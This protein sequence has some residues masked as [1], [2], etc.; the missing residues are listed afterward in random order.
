MAITHQISDGPAHAVA[1]LYLTEGQTVRAEQGALVAMSPNVEL[2][3][4]TSEGVV[5]LL[6]EAGKKTRRT[7]FSNLYTPRNGGG[8]V[9]L[10]PMLPGSIE[11][12]NLEHRTFHVSSAA[13]L[14]CSPELELDI[15]IANA[16]TFFSAND[17]FLFGISGT[18]MLMLGA[19]GGCH[20]LTL[21]AG[22]SLALDTGH[23]LAFEAHTRYKLEKAAKSALV[24]MMTQ[25][26]LVAV[27]EGPGSVLI[28]TRNPI[29]LAAG[30]SPLLEQ[31]RKVNA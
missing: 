5:Q 2:H 18:G 23:V 15:E 8:K 14:A 26:T 20:N 22:E 9:I 29:Q 6:Q 12:L 1:H 21:Q 31:A 27:F 16:S 30:L 19:Y 25:E 11:V 10:A 4:D 7:Q 28:Q 3:A 17:L 13:F 24:S